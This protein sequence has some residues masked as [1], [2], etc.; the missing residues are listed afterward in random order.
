MYVLGMNV[1]MIQTFFAQVQEEVLTAAEA[2]HRIQRALGLGE[3]SDSKHNQFD[4]EKELIL[5]EIGF[6]TLMTDPELNSAFNPKHGKVH[7]HNPLINPN[8]LNEHD[9]LDRYT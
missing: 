4:P 9:H 3:G 7:Q 5:D 1:H 2:R 8:N 6:Y